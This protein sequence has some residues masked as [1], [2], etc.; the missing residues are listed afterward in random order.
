M[1]DVRRLG[2]RMPVAA[3]VAVSHVVGQDQDDTSA[4]D[5][6]VGFALAPSNG[7]GQ[8]HGEQGQH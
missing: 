1:V 7:R 2:D 4:P 3:Q 6:P 8:A 5:P